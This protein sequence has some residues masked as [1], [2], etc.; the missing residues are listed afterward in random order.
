VAKTLSGVTILLV[1]D[2]KDTREMFARALEQRGAVVLQAASAQVALL[3]IET[4]RPGLAIVD[5]EL[6]DVDGWDLMDAMR[7]LTGRKIPPVIAVSAHSEPEDRRRSL[8]AGFL[9]HV[10]KPVDGDRLADIATAVT[11]QPA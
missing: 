6:P 1:E 4:T 5:I 8:L 3:W 11:A 2:H 9:L 10:A 7:R